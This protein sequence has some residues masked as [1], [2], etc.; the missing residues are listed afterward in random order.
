MENI[1]ALK[2]RIEKQDWRKITLYDALAYVFIANKVLKNDD[3]MPALAD[4][5]NCKA[6]HLYPQYEFI[7]NRKEQVLLQLIDLTLTMNKD[8]MNDKVSELQN[9]LH[10]TLKLQDDENNLFYEASYR[11]I[12]AQD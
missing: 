8:N 6:P 1:N 11:E 10:M 12:G 4:E 3:L 9:I 7:K 5:I 2:H